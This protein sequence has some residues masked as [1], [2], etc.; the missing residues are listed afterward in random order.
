VRVVPPELLRA[1]RKLCDEHGL[2][3]VLDEVQSGMGRS[4][5]LFAYQRCG[6]APDIM[7][8]AKALG[9]ASLW[10]PASR[11]RRPPKA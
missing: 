8:L 10:E 1:L 4:G 5:E 3:L 2:L 7:A 6:V 9:A 11:P